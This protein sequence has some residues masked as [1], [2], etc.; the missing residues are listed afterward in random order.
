[1][2]FMATCHVQTVFVEGACVLWPPDES[3]YFRNSCKMCGV[4]TTDRTTTDDADALHLG[5]SPAIAPRDI[6]AR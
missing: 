6:L 5:V 1:M 3:P 2:K 4:K